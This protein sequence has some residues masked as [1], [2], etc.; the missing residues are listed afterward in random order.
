MSGEAISPPSASAASAKMKRAETLDAALDVMSMQPGVPP[1]AKHAA[2]AAVIRRSGPGVVGLGDSQ[3]RGKRPSEM[4]PALSEA[5]Q[6][7]YKQYWDQYRGE[8]GQAGAAPPCSSWTG[9]MSQQW[10]AQMGNRMPECGEQAKSDVGEMFAAVQAVATAET[11]QA[12]SAQTIAAQSSTPQA[13]ATPFGMAANPTNLAPSESPA[14]AAAKPTPEVTAPALAA[15]S[16]LTQQQ[17]PSMA[18]AAPPFL[19]QREATGLAPVAAPVIGTLAPVTATAPHTTQQ[20]SPTTVA[21]VGAPHTI[22]H[23]S[24]ANLAAVGGLEAASDST[25]QQSRAALAAFTPAASDHNQQQSR[26]TLAPVIATA[27]DTTQQQSPT[28]VA[29]LIQQQSTATLAPVGGSTA[30][31]PDSSQTA[32][33]AACVATVAAASNCNQQQPPEP[34]QANGRTCADLDP[35][36][37]SDSSRPGISPLQYSSRKPTGRTQAHGNT[38]ADPGSPP[39]PPWRTRE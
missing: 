7:K 9:S 2:E 28:T 15:P 29:P 32:P 20:Q 23:Q 36:C 4:L 35:P 30:A 8:Q 34:S 27:L 37:T 18:A 3:C 33:V 17:S 38:R 21:P 22:Q 31:A 19:A 11:G 39:G 24:P 6:K 13:E 1:I 25:V 14:A 26:A 10:L 16:V 12:A 5:D